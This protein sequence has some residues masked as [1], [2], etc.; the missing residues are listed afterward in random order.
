MEYTTS[1]VKASKKVIC[2]FKCHHCDKINF[3]SVTVTEEGSATTT[4][5]PFSRAKRAQRDQELGE[6]AANHAK[7]KV[8]GKIEL[9]EKKVNENR[10]TN[11]VYLPCICRACKKNQV[12]GDIPELTM[13]EMAAF[14]VTA[15]LIGLFVPAWCIENEMARAICS[16]ILTALPLI[17]ILL[18]G[19]KAIV[20]QKRTDALSIDYL[21]VLMTDYNSKAL[22]ESI[23]A[24]QPLP[25]VCSEKNPRVNTLNTILNLIRQ[26]CFVG[27]CV[28]LAGYLSG[29]SR[30]ASIKAGLT[31]C[32]YFF[33]AG[34]IILQF[35]SLINKAR[36][37][38]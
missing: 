28:C 6:A 23:A 21:P 1:K 36:G 14:M 5:S 15:M 8:Q 33:T 32:G 38:N 10:S 25:S 12:W 35:L 27:I 37:G 3:S 7:E 31:Y 20:N 9:Y 26:I 11:G 24:G 29:G 13:K 16:M 34:Y 19:P 18:T 22:L 30:I 4:Y 2:Y 17:F